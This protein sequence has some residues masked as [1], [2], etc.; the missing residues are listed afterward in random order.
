MNL[1]DILIFTLGASVGSLLTWRVVKGYYEK[2][3]QEEIDALNED[4]RNYEP[5]RYTHEELRETVEGVLIDENK[6][7]EEHLDEYEDIIEDQGY[8][9]VEDFEKDCEM[10]VSTM[11]GKP[12]AIPPEQFGENDYRMV[13]ITYFA[14]KVLMDD[15][16]D[17][18]TDKEVEEKIGFF[19]L[20]TFGK[21][22]EEDRIFVRNDEY[23][24][25]YEILL[26]NRI[27]SEEFPD[28]LENE[29]ED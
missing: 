8:T 22:V 3:W 11:D 17:V 18:L 12:Y 19:N 13:E 21:Y 24:T 15:D 6:T 23:E 5:R 9:S 2:I 26:D 29:Y 14:D 27:Y 10:E 25:D 1:K 20:N 16:G 28:E 7:V 4:I